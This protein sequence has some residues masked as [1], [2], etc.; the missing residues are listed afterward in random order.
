MGVLCMRDIFYNNKFFKISIL[1]EG[2]GVGM[3]KEGSVIAGWLL[4]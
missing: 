3:M 1:D 4:M 2:G